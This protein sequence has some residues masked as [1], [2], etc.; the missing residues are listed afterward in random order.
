MA[1]NELL[2][3]RRA[4]TRTSGRSKAGYDHFARWY[5]PDSRAI[6]SGFRRGKKGAA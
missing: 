1:L 4:T 6:L 3:D 2:V 5:G